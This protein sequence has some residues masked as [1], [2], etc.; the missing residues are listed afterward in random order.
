LLCSC[1][2]DPGTLVR[3]WKTGRH[4]DFSNNG[5]FNGG[6]FNG[7]R[8]HLAALGR[9]ADSIR[10]AR[11]VLVEQVGP[12]YIRWAE[13]LGRDAKAVRAHVLRTS[14]GLKVLAQELSN[15]PLAGNTRGAKT[16]VEAARAVHQKYRKKGFTP[17]DPSTMGGAPFETAC[18]YRRPDGQAAH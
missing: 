10:F 4:G 18:Q 14:R 2:Q 16:V 13:R 8:A 7:P 6:Y 5:H 9:D 12:V 15:P 1:S 3:R 17:L 11:R